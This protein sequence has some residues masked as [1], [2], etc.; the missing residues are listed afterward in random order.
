MVRGVGQG[1]VMGFF[2]ALANVFRGDG[3]QNT[4][5]GIGANSKEVSLRGRYRI[6]DETLELLYSEDGFAARIV[7][8]VPGE[9]LRR[10]IGVAIKDVAIAEGIDARLDEL[11]APARLHDG[12][13]WGRCF[14]GSLVLIGVDDERPT[15]QPVDESSIKAVRFLTA[16]DKRDVQI[17]SYFEDALSPKYGT[18]R[19]YRVQQQGG[20]SSIS[21]VWHASRVIRFDGVLTTRR[22]MRKNNG[23][24]DSVLQRVY[25]QLVAFNGAFASVSSLLSE[26][27]VGV[28]KIKGLAGLILGDNED[29]LKRRLAIMDQAKSVTRSL[30]ID[31]DG[32]DYSRVEAA[33]LSGLPDTLDRYMMFLAGVSR[34]PVTILMGRAPAGLNATGES[35]MRAFYS[36]VASET[37]NVLKPRATKLVRYLLLAKEG[38]TGGIEPKGWEVKFPSLWEE[39]PKEQ[40]EGRKLVADTDAIYVTHQVLTPEEIAVTRFR[41]EGWSEETSIETTAREAIV[42]ADAGGVANPT[43][44]SVAPADAA[45]ATDPNAKDPAAA[46][47][48]A[49]VASMQEIITS[50]AARMIPRETGIQ[51]LLRAFPFTAAEAEMTMGE[52]GRTFFT[53]PEPGQAIEM[54]SLRGEAKTATSSLARYKALLRRVLA[55]NRAGELVVGS[56]VGTNG[57]GSEVSDEEV[58]SILNAV[59]TGEELTTALDSL[60]ASRRDAAQARTDAAEHTGLAI[61]LPVSRSLAQ[62]LAVPGGEDPADLHCTLAF[63]GDTTALPEDLPA[64]VSALI[65][66]WAEQQRPLAGVIAGQGRFIAGEDGADPVYLSPDVPGLSEARESLVAFLETS[67]IAVVATHGFTPHITL[68]YVGAG[69]PSPA[70]PT[71][72]APIQFDRVAVWAGPNRAE[73]SLTG[74]EK[75]S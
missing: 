70:A 44:P 64:T 60:N 2:D 46:L 57:S 54:D 59:G 24:A 71:E 12:W 53:A 58:E 8:A 7:D 50:V 72:T 39:T 51:E 55:K 25:D 29:K 43:D 11:S 65:R 22:R 4:L 20:T 33:A 13:V 1:E 32:E 21:A 15:D 49:Q 3:W 30:L 68:A 26:S 37:T 75:E 42:A 16:V 9:A 61:V 66:T 6:D 45:V 47:N 56:P 67:G 17:A 18:P 27:S 23:W 38:P 69:D 19:T 48:G 40:R 10:G 41:K 35:D 28:F 36:N 31:A 74:T 73:F 14:G 52:V 5:T 62:R 63:L 34:I